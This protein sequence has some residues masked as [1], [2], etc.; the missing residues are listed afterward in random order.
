[1]K[2]IVLLLTLSLLLF[3]CSERTPLSK[4][5]KH[6]AGKWI[7][8]DGTWIQL[9]NDG[10]GN[11]QLSNSSVSGASSIITDSTIVIEV[12]GLGNVFY[13]TKAPYNDQGIWKIELDENIY[14]KQ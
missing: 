3:G 4:E 8:S 2:K 5:H 1:M 7:A 12:L 10:V 11:F 13:I 14:V 9:F 6:Y